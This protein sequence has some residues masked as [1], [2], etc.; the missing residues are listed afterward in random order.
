MRAVPRRMGTR[1]SYYLLQPLQTVRFQSFTCPGVRSV[2]NSGL[3]HG[4][5]RESNFG[6]SVAL[7][8]P[9]RDGC[10]KSTGIGTNTSFAPPSA[11]ISALQKRLTPPTLEEMGI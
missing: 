3:T 11:G 7:Q 4:T 5:G 9:L 8:A 6:S 1:K 2:R 10:L